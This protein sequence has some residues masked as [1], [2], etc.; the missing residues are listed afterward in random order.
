MRTDPGGSASHP[1]PPAETA[2]AAKLE[3]LMRSLEQLRGL[4][5]TL[6]IPRKDKVPTD[7][8]RDLHYAANW[9][10]LMAGAVE[11][12]PAV[13]RWTPDYLK[14]VVGNA[15]VQVQ[16]DRTAD[17]DF[18]RRMADHAATLPFDAFIDRISRP[19]AGNEA[20]MTAYNSAQNAQALAPLHA[21][22]DFLGAYLSR[23]ADRP[24]GMMWI[25]PR[26][27]FT[28]LHHDLTNNL[29]LQ[30]VGRK[31]VLMAPP[32]ETP[33]LYNDHHVYSRI[34][35]LTAPDVLARFPKLEGVRVHRVALD[36]GDALFI[37]L[38]WWH[39]VSALDFSVTITHT[40][41][42]WPNDAYATYPRT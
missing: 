19:D 7:E 10:V 24:H 16:V 33:R 4:S 2:S 8:F 18:E 21:D 15:P 6:A 30:L 32:G 39:Q 23:D 37:P 13:R 17:P 20:Y 42:L 36:P 29:L 14:A 9:P 31:V 28:P 11:R 22:L 12:W 38:G 25:G 5:S 34:R 27:A 1:E 3:W 40:N 41:F 26:G 35:D